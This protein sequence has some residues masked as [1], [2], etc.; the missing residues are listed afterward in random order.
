MA[1]KKFS[2]NDS[3]QQQSTREPSTRSGDRSSLEANSFSVSGAGTSQNGIL[4]SLSKLGGGSY[5]SY[6]VDHLARMHSEIE[7]TTRK[8]EL[9]QRRLHTLDKALGI[10]ESEYK[11][12][13]TKYEGAHQ[14]QAGVA[15]SAEHHVSQLERRL[16]YAIA[17]LNQGKCENDELRKHIDQ[18]RKER[19]ILDAV[20]KR[21]EK[22][23]N[24]N[25]RSIEQVK[26]NINDSKQDTEG[27]KQRTRAL[28]KM[29]ERERRNFQR[30]CERLKTEMHKEHE[31]AKEQENLQRS[32]RSPEGP[33][34][35]G[36][37]PRTKQ[38]RAYMVADEEEAFSEQMMH[39]RILKLSFLN[40][41]QRRHIK[42]HQKNIE[43][44]E[45]AF[46]TIKS[47]TGI[48]DIEQIV[49]IFIA[50]E[51]RNFSLLTYVN[52]LNREIESI[53]IRNRELQNQLVDYKKEQ[54]DS[55]AR[56]NQALSELSVQITKTI[57]ATEEKDKMISDATAS[58]QL[59]RPLIWSVVKYLK[60]HMPGLAQSAYEGD[61]PPQKVAEPD[62]HD[63]NLN[64]YLMYIEDCI[65]M[66]RVCLTNTLDGKGPLVALN[67]QLPKPLAPTAASGSTKKPQTQELPSAHITGEDSDDDDPA[68]GD[69]EGRP[70]TRS[71]LRKNAE[72]KI[73]KRRQNRA[74]QHGKQPGVDETKETRRVELD[75]ATGSSEPTSSQTRR[76]DPGPPPAKGE[77]A[78]SSSV[79]SK[80]AS[81]PPFSKSP[82][83]SGAGAGP[84][85]DDEAG[86]RKDLWWREKNSKDK[87][88]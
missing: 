9:E 36:G 46:A 40:T 35:T 80:D 52:Q 77:Y 24:S 67:A 69:K 19:Q 42:Q 54:T 29:L 37:G 26:S 5:R 44:F 59:C 85:D 50:L 18:L 49:Q 27:F 70:L 88:K 62:E 47:S 83:M 87:R 61:P 3:L 17:E 2:P 75:E 64:N 10:A 33:G 31:V 65:M 78:A 16:E 23:I 8:L 45:Q 58:L 53:E 82:S 86:D 55:S 6:L 71:Q 38:R 7:A 25:R 43:V 11:S 68:A 63:E 13:R 84:A 20:F 15:K 76:N 48:S 1:S 66:F 34:G 39:R 51:Q 73:Q 72:A 12:K 14:H 79:Q 60:E 81:D 4:S 57:S 41:I 32:S 30:E 28:T 22:D 56:K 74:G 21:L